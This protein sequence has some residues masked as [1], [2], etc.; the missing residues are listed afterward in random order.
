MKNIYF[1][2]G[3]TSSHTRFEYHFL[4]FSLSNGKARVDLKK[5]GKMLIDDSYI[6]PGTNIAGL[7]FW[8]FRIRPYS[9][10]RVEIYRSAIS[11]IKNSFFLGIGPGNW[12]LNV[13]DP[14]KNDFALIYQAHH[15][16]GHHS[17]NNFLQIG[18]ESGFLAALLFLILVFWPVIIGMKNLLLYKNKFPHADSLYVLLLCFICINLSGIF[19]YTVFSGVG[20]NIFW[21]CYALIF[22]NKKVFFG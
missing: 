3:K 8:N 20:G 14:Q 19:D 16:T 13:N 18:L 9:V 12:K 1:L 17:H 15:Y 5:S 11:L 2:K 6:I 22:Q 7:K 4:P 21:L 10:L